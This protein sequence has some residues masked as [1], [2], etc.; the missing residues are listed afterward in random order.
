M[1]LEPRLLQEFVKC[2]AR[3]LDYY[4][5]T[6]AKCNH[7]FDE[8]M[9]IAVAFQEVPVESTDLVVLAVCIFPS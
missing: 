5:S 9:N 6:R 7:H 2:Q 3:V 1:P 4:V 8:A